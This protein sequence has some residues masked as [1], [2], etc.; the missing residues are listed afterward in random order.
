M[1][2]KHKNPTAEVA[3]DGVIPLSSTAAL[4]ELSAQRHAE[5]LLV[6]N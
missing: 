6:A 5:Q 4:S 2:M 3:A 1:P